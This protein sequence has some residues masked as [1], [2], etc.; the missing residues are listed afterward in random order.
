MTEPTSNP[1]E[2][3]SPEPET[4][5]ERASLG[6]LLRKAREARGLSIADIVAALKYSPRQIEALEADQLSALPSSVFVRGIVRSYA[7]MLKLDPEP[8][9]ELLQTEIPVAPPEVR[10][11]EDMGVAMPRASRQNS[12]LMVGLMLVT[13]VA[14]IGGLWHF[15]AP[16]QPPVAPLAEQQGAVDLP[17]PA[18]PSPTPDRAS[19]GDIQAL[20]APVPDIAA[21]VAV[22]M[23]QPK[24]PVVDSTLP[25]PAGGRPL[26][27][28]FRGTSWVE[29]KDATQR[30]IFTGQ[31]LAGT[32]QV[33]LGQ[34]P[35]QIVIGNAPLVD[36]KYEGR[37]VDLAPHIRADVAR[38]TLE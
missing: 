11:P 38:L 8:L 4:P 35:F 19:V 33:A 22:P 18:M 20:P 28:E 10:P 16:T 2:E 24:A 6:L 30:I 14:V 5:A 32:K 23:E 13:V 25:V 1:V 29:V 36:L 34:P 3:A 7:R 15:L 17:A 21:P 31:Y 9:L 27:F 37:S 12:V 26:S